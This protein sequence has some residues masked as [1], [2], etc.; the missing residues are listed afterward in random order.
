MRHPYSTDIPGI[1]RTLF[2]DRRNLFAPEQHPRRPSLGAM[3]FP[4][5]S[6]TTYAR[7][8][9]HFIIAFVLAL[10]LLLLVSS[11]AQTYQRF[12]GKPQQQ[13][14]QI[15]EET[16]SQPKVPPPTYEKLR[17][18]QDNLPQHDLSLPFPEGKTGRYVKFSNQIV[19]LGWNNVLNEVLMNAHLAY[20]SKRAYVFQDYVW[21]PEYYPW[22][23]NQRLSNPPRTPLSALI[24]GTVVG[25]PFDEGDDAPRSISETWFDVV[26]PWKERRFI[27][28]NE[29]KQ[30]LAWKNG[31][32]TFDGWAKILRDAPERCIE[33]QA[34]GDD[35]FPQI[36]DLWLWGSDRILPLWDSFSKS[37]TSRLLR[38]S[39]IVGAAVKRNEYLFLPRGPRPA[40]PVSPDPYARMLAMHIRRGDF[41]GAC[42]H[43]A[44]WNST[45]YSWN[46]LP[47]LPDRLE[48][49]AHIVWNT[50]EYFEAH[51]E[52]CLPDFDAIIKKARDSRDDYVKAAP[53]KRRTLDIM[54]LLTNEKGEWIE[55]LKKALKKDGWHTIVTSNDLELDSEGVDTGM[56][57]DMD[58]A[59]KAAVFVGNGWS[60]FTSN[61][62]HRRLVDGKE[63]IS[64]RFW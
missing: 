39:P 41:K 15:Y 16:L 40:H 31:Q 17:K 9:L 38:T 62:N 33:V 35:K 3:P 25:Q 36:F 2:A 8:K 48:F 22:P 61:I 14:P 7:Y 12:M 45:F 54:Y 46:L 57:I 20:A 24:A 63:P 42:T 26:C 59:R 5:S 32:E 11:P 13:P 64:I 27:G 51:A 37:P 21:K 55:K 1:R 30:S 23:E 19:M 56:A 53:G 18:W 34:T 52:R 29:I 6:R 4:H 60:S 44:T 43:L 47:Q 50:T 10:T 49:P 28:T 58:I